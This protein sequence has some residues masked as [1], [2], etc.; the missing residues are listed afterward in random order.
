ML[1]TFY[2]QKYLLKYSLIN[3]YFEKIEGLLLQFL[4]FDLIP[5]CSDM[6]VNSFTKYPEIYR[7]FKGLSQADRES[8]QKLQ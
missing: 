7:L 2:W 4:G 6:S 3:P 1:D 5:K 8:A